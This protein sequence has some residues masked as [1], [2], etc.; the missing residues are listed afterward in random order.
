MTKDDEEAFAKQRSDD[1][2]RFISALTHYI[3]MNPG[4]RF[5]Q[6]LINFWFVTGLL[7]NKKCTTWKNEFSIEPRDILKRLGDMQLEDCSKQ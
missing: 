7:E 5:S 4:Y 2:Q 1:N 6:I 3:E